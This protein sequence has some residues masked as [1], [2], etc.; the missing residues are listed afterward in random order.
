MAPARVLF[1]KNAPSAAAG[2]AA[3]GG[4]TPAATATSTYI[5]YN[6]KYPNVN[7]PTA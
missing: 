6:Y 2:P 7:Q 5:V 3:A 4:P 1:G